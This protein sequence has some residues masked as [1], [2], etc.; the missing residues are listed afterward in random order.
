M[1]FRS[2]KTLRTFYCFPRCIN[3]ELDGEAEHPGL[4]RELYCGMQSLQSVAKHA[5][6]HQ[7]YNL[8]FNRYKSPVMPPE[9]VIQLYS[10]LFSLSSEIWIVYIM[11]NLKMLSLLLVLSLSKTLF[12]RGEGLRCHLECLHHIMKL[13]SFKSQFF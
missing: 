12:L 4:E 10:Q 3:R 6:Q 5:A 1:S 9:Q 7:L 2:P 8:D 13:P 11:H